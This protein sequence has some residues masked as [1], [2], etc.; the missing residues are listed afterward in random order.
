VLAVLAS[1]L[2][3]GCAGVLPQVE[4]VPSRTLVASPEA[5]LPAAVR[6]A[7]LPEGES[8][9]WP[10]LQATYALDARP[11]SRDVARHLPL[12]VLSCMRD[13]IGSRAMTPTGA[14]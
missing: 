9:V 8:G 7:Q 4:R 2:V 11:R 10:L 12:P 13:S 14:A 5:A 6:A 1:L 3:T